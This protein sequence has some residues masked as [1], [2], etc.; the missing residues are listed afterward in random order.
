M[1]NHFA[2][3]FQ[4]LIHSRPK[5]AD[6][7]GTALPQ[8]M[9]LTRPHFY[10]YFMRMSSKEAGDSIPASTK[11]NKGF[12]LIPKDWSTAPVFSPNKQ[13]GVREIVVNG[14][15][16][17]MGIA[18]PLTNAPSAS[19]D[20]AHVRILLAVLS[21]WQGCNPL[22]MSL[23]E[24]GKRAAGAHG[25]AYF[26]L[27]RQRLGQLR[28]YWIAVDLKS[29]DKRMFP[30]I[31]R[32]EI[33]S[34]KIHSRRTDSDAQ[35][36]LALDEWGVEDSGA[37]DEGLRFLQLENVALAPEFAEFLSDFTNL[38]HVRLD[39][40]RTLPSDVA[41]AL[42]LFIPSRAVHR[43]K[44]DPWKINLT[45]LFEQLAMAIPSS[46]SRRRRILTQHA[47]KSVV[48]QLDGARILN[49][50]L[51]VGLKLNR[52]ETDWMLLAWVDDPDDTPD[53]SETQSA[54]V[55]AWNDSGRRQ[56]ELLK[57]LRSRLPDLSEEEGYLCE[58]AKVELPKVE[59]FLQLCKVAI[60]SA[61]LR[62]TLAE[63][64][65][66]VIEKRGPIKS[67]TGT[68][69]WR[70]LQL[71]SQPVQPLAMPATDTEPVQPATRLRRASR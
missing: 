11:K 23:K 12:S 49:G 13:V 35:Q 54:L 50:N 16:W 26:K 71:V 5:L 34:R 42:Y 64:K 60:G 55:K 51:R 61:A 14:N 63:L 70:L 46:K 53:L 10:S 18:N 28:D 43:N 3:P 39:V 30:A 62:R 56:E 31:S 40:L 52:E 69:L 24:L 19:I 38:M 2:S 33:T 37:P 48:Q 44:T 7:V 58:A 47:R 27:L 20:M 45:N 67:P 66:D 59:R 22:S 6:T 57:L 32:I 25:G 65:I 29:G 9:A 36:R 4:K 21:F 15:T 1:R 68:L 17:K 8:P 41:Q